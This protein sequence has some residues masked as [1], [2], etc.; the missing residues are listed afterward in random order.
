MNP[1][2]LRNRRLDQFHGVVAIPFGGTGHV[3]DLAALG[4][5]QYRGRH[6]EREPDALEVLEHLGLGV[7]EVAELGQVGA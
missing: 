5:D 1:S 4:V 3:G 6:A 2:L 7:A